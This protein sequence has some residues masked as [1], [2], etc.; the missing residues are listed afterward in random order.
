[1]R[2]PRTARP[3]RDVGVCGLWYLPLKTAYAV[4]L[5]QRG[6]V[7]LWGDL[8]NLDKWTAQTINRRLTEQWAWDSLH[9]W[10]SDS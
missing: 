10:R 9:H 1:M 7:V 8:S 2:I 3:R 6:L 4:A 5:V